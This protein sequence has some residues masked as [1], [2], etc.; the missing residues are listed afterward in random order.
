VNWEQL[1][2]IFDRALEL[3]GDKRVQFLDDACGGDAGLRSE[4][5]DL[6]ESYEAADGFLSDEMQSDNT[7][8]AR[9]AGAPT[10]DEFPVVDRYQVCARIGAGG[11]G[12]VYLAEQLEPLQRHV[13]LKVIRS[14]VLSQ[15]VIKRFEAER[16]VLARMDHPNIAA[17]FDAG[18]TAAGRPYLVMEYVDGCSIVKYCDDRR[19]TLRDRLAL[20]LGVCAGVQHAHQ[21]GIVHRDIKPSNVLVP[22]RD[23]DVIPKVIDFGVAK[24]LEPDRSELS[25]TTQ[26]QILGT[27]VYMSPEQAAA[28]TEKIDTRSD[29][30]SLGVLLYELLT[31]TTP[32]DSK[33]LMSAG[34]GEMIRVIQTVD[35][36]R[37]STRVA[38]ALTQQD[39]TKD[40]S[41][42]AAPSDASAHYR[43]T[44]SS[45]LFRN[46][47]GDLDWI[48]MKCLEKDPDRRYS[49]AAAL[50]DDLQRYLDVRSIA[51]RPPSVGDRVR[52][53]VRRNRA[54]AI[55]SIALVVALVG[56]ATASTLGFLR[57]SD[58][59][60][61]AQQ[62]ERSARAVTRYLAG[63]LSEAS[64]T[65]LG[66]DATVGEILDRR[67]DELSDRFKDQPLVEAEV[68]RTIGDAYSG[69][70]WFE[71][72]A[73]HLR[74]AVELYQMET[75]QG[76]DT[77]HAKVRLAANRR[78]AGQYE[79]AA[80]MLND[81]LIA[82][83]EADDIPVRQKLI[84]E[85]ELATL[86]RIQ[87]KY[88][89][90]GE[91]SERV[92]TESM[93][94]LGADDELTLS[95]Q[96]NLASLYD[97]TDRRAEAL[98]LLNDALATQV[99][100]LG[101]THPDT[102]L[103]RF[104]LAIRNCLDGQH[105][106]AVELYPALL[107]DYASRLGS[108]H[109]MTNAVRS[110]FAFELAHVGRLSE[111]DALITST[112]ADQQAR[113]PATHRDVVES[114]RHGVEIKESLGAFEDA[115]PLA[116]QRLDALRQLYGDLDRQVLT[117]I[118]NLGASYRSVGDVEKS[119][120]LLRQGIQG[121][122]AALGPTHFETANSMAHLISLLHEQERHQEEA[123][124]IEEGLAAF[125]DIAIED[126]A[127]YQGLRHRRG[128]LMRAQGRHAD[129]IE[130]FR[131]TFHAQLDTI[132]NLA[133][134]IHYGDCLTNELLRQAQY[135]EAKHV[136]EQV[137]SGCDQS[138][139][140]NTLKVASFLDRHAHCCM[141]L[142]AFE[143]GYQSAKKSLELRRALQPEDE[144]ALSGSKMLLGVCA[145]KLEKYDEA[146]VLLR[147]V[148][149]VREGVLNP[150]NWLL[151]NTRSVLGECLWRGGDRNE[152][153]V[154]IEQAHAALLSISSTP[155]QR[156]R[157]SEQRMALIAGQVGA[158]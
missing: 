91:W 76:Q 128:H 120:S 141:Q 29:I 77:L 99:D 65:R 102:L 140:A 107:E 44:D 2:T 82:Y 63:I 79:I 56:G 89:A 14:G 46:L 146:E 155:A 80:Q 154:L 95:A 9:D 94:S 57:A 134:V 143:I 100:T 156:R 149:A 35:P 64:P 27:P 26:Q 97:A 20:F 104:N 23:E 25:L 150:D 124:L 144:Y 115:I 7:A 101:A 16:Q 105:A 71:K 24:A 5:E 53:L 8:G 118:I 148:L 138:P 78:G 21:K 111:A 41:V 135:D 74:R 87:K 139:Q 96:Q 34:V 55:I 59:R 72:G 85:Y 10:P 18:E 15:S 93:A 38:A 17:V 108:D 109:R 48:V 1:K 84:A 86:L 4:V 54:A 67:D 13:A 75:G 61:D 110:Y 45:T 157:E 19:L 3:D 130:D 113:L 40:V 69:M 42:G 47:R 58:A 131:A 11:F 112:L 37:P 151:H 122:R 70:G 32:F 52:K 116:Q 39:K 43:R 66:P 126:H 142:K 49:T 60:D 106:L 121:F 12:T 125:R 117:A 31:G 22:T 158:G 147:E 98:E 145:L 127:G 68:R 133:Q 114:L 103:S 62:A 90:A 50:A 152:A 136:I 73:E 153:R 81:V 137:L 123:A 30:Y 129:A 88:R 132:R 83:G 6:L 28:A 36:E 33:A 119:E 51:A 92:Y